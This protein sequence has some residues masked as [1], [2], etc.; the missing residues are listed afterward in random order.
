MLCRVADLAVDAAFEAA[1]AKYPDK[2]ICIRERVITTGSRGLC[3]S[4]I[5]SGHMVV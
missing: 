4:Q 3:L 1:V 5:K 2:R